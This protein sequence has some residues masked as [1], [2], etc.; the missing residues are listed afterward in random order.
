MRLD[1][2]PMV[3]GDD[4]VTQLKPY[5]MNKNL[6][7]YQVELAN[8]NAITAIKR[9]LTKQ[10]SNVQ[11][12]VGSS[13]CIN[14]GSSESQYIYA[15]GLLNSKIQACKELDL[16]FTSYL[17][18]KLEVLSLLSLTVEFNEFN[19]FYQEQAKLVR[20]LFD[21]LS[22]ED[23]ITLQRIEVE[24]VQVKDWENRANEE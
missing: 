9:E 18:D 11:I 22:D 4:I 10:R 23:K 8:L 20:M 7:E 12:N 3:S 14:A 13:V 5:I 21:N 2:T 19:S 16:D 6:S 17:N 1:E 15:T 24:L